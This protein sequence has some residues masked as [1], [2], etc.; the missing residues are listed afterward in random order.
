MHSI[1]DIKQGVVKGDFLLLAKAISFIEN[2]AAGT[3]GFLEALAPAHIPIIGVTGP[4][5]AGKSTL[6]N[7]LISAW[8]E[9]GKKIAVLSVDPSSP[10]HQGAILGDR[11]RM[12]DWYLHPQVYIR[13]LAARGHLG[14]LNSAMLSLT[15]LMQSAGFDYIVVETVGVGQSEVEIAS[16]ADTTVVVLVPEAGD[17]VQMMKSGLMEIANVFVVNKS[18]RPNAQIFVNHLKQMIAENAPTENTPQVVSTIATEREGVADLLNVIQVHQLALHNGA[19]KNEMLFTKVMQLIVASKMNKVDIEKVK[20]HLALE[21]TKAH[22][23]IF[24]FAQ[25]FY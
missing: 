16:L 2:N 11:I 8:V 4:P 10:F 7:A 13:S 21:S 24:K 22:F 15:T 12:K 3:T 17:E 18:D 23:N 9:A 5:G 6:I 14:G 25:S 1:S 19:Q 20:T